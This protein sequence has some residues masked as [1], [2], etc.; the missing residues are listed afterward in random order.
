LGILFAERKLKEREFSTWKEMIEA[1]TTIRNDSTGKQLQRVSCEW[2][3]RLTWV[4]EHGRSITANDCYSFF[5]E[6]ELMD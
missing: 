1:I 2:I 3:H 4:G 5:K 6:L